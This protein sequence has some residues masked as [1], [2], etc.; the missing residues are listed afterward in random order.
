MTPCRSISPMLPL[1]ARSWR[2]GAGSKVET[3]GDVFQVREDD[4]APWGRVGAA[5]A[6]VMPSELRPAAR[7]SRR[8]DL[9]ATGPN[10]A[11][12][13]KCM[14]RAA[15]ASVLNQSV[16]LVTPRGPGNG[17]RADRASPGLARRRKTGPA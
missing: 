2:G 11:S 7:S 1:R 14:D 9:A 4:P 13:P 8:R 16:E 3:A 10:G 17:V 5:S 6:A 15:A 12:R